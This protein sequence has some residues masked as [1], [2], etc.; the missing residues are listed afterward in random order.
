MV[1]NDFLYIFEGDEDV[2]RSW[3]LGTTW[4]KV[5]DDFDQSEKTGNAIGSA[6]NMVGSLFIV[7]R[8]A[9]VY[10]TDDNGYNWTLVN[11][12]YNGQDPD[13]ASSMSV[14]GNTLFILDDQA[15]WR[16]SDGGQSWKKVNED[17]NNITDADSGRLLTADF[18][19][20]LYALDNGESLFISKD[21]GHNWE[22][23]HENI[24]SGNGNING[25]VSYVQPPLKIQ[26]R[27]SNNP[28]AWSDY[29][30]PD[31]STRTYYTSTFANLNVPSLRY[32]QY[33]AYFESSDPD[34]SPLL[35]NLTVQFTPPPS[36]TP[37]F[38]RLESPEHDYKSEVSSI[39]LTCSATDDVKVSR[40]E[41]YTNMTG[42][43][44]YRSTD[45]I[46]FSTTIDAIR[47]GTYAWSC[48]AYDNFNQKAWGP[49]RTF[50]IL[51]PVDINISGNCT[52]DWSCR[53]WSQCFIDTQS[54]TCE[55]L[56]GCTPDLKIETQPC[57]VPG[58]AANKTT[59]LDILVPREE[60]REEFEEFIENAESG[61][62]PKEP[63]ERAEPSVETPLMTSSFS[64][65]LII[66]VIA[67]VAGIL[68]SVAIRSS[69]P[70]MF[71]G[72]K[73]TRHSDYT[74]GE[75]TA[76]IH[77]KK[78][79][80][81][82][83]KNEEERLTEKKAKKEKRSEVAPA[84]DKPEALVKKSWFSFKRSE[85]KPGPKR[86]VVIQE[87]VYE[88]YD[89]KDLTYEKPEAVYHRHSYKTES[90]PE[91]EPES[92]FESDSDYR[93]D[94]E[95][96][97][98]SKTDAFEEG[99]EDG[100]YKEKIPLHK[101]GSRLRTLHQSRDEF[102]KD[103]K[104]LRKSI[105][106]KEAPQELYRFETPEKEPEVVEETSVL[107]KP[108]IARIREVSKERKG[109]SKVEDID[110][111]EYP[112]LEHVKEL[113]EEELLEK[114]Q[115]LDDIKTLEQKLEHEHDLLLK[116]K[117]KFKIFMQRIR[118]LDNK[119][120]RDR[121]RLEKEQKERMKKLQELK[122]ILSME[123]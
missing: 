8:D 57:I 116:K 114:E 30:G 54:R 3:D 78:D 123:E 109:G 108:K 95:F 65:L 113:L 81:V 118:I 55:D 121:K 1:L 80:I 115:E 103:R 100:A 33:K 120:K 21:Y 5:R 15:V 64:T 111:G 16:S 20:N 40:L 12:D 53:D 82:A 19:G 27:S 22:L 32:F 68:T 31:G 25:L 106:L 89:D 122:S 29:I 85:H 49:N 9:S 72:K 48:L 70:D 67:A 61:S 2:W 56:N 39:T 75:E 51:P 11:S 59:D 41:L 102:H 101:A 37:P 26:V 77:E 96:D 86:P 10:R 4:V 88:E 87:K 52:P 45:G 119:I 50:M 36:D 38:V 110:F 98:G 66:L 84:E 43:S 117:S 90:E 91:S 97:S 76:D 24:N 74:W 28:G 7:T 18:K 92:E 69:V 42:W 99:F 44:L 112:D 62:R 60:T 23:L 71:K 58:I 6:V 73:K 34:Y 104:R 47:Q 14:I 107:V 17:F 83:E 63:G 93:S 105:A 13:R 79:G 35:Q 46:A 94:S